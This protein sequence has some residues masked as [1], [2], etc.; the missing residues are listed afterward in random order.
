MRKVNNK[1]SRTT[2]NKKRYEILFFLQL[3]N[4]YQ[5]KNIHVAL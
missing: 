4:K 2:P 1:D 3:Y 5:Q